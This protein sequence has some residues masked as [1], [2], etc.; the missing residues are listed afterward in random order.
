MGVYRPWSLQDL[1]VRLGANVDHGH[2]AKLVLEFVRGYVESDA[3]D[4]PSLIAEP[5]PLTG[6]R[7]WDATVA[8]LADHYAAEDRLARPRW[9]DEPART[10][11]PPFAVVDTPGV[12][13]MA[14]VHSPAAFLAHGVLLLPEDLSPV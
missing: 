6:H 3:A 4:R 2:R 5:P 12:R 8:A 9:V 7:G 10:T 1:A 13:T 11:F 14:L